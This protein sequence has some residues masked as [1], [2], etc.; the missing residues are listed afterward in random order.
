MI[1]TRSSAPVFTTYYGS[2]TYE[3]VA[4]IMQNGKDVT[5]K[6]STKNLKF[7]EGIQDEQTYYKVYNDVDSVPLPLLVGVY[8]DAN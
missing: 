3:Y 2:N 4:K 6:Y 5:A 1:I 8:T 7:R